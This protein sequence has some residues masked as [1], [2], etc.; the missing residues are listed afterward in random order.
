MRT[1][2]PCPFKFENMHKGPSRD[3]LDN[4]NALMKMTNMPIAVDP[5]ELA[6]KKMSMKPL[7]QPASTKKWVANLEK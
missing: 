3:Y 6:K 1:T 5:V 7:R 2:E 4:E